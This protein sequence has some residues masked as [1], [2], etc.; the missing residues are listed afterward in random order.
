[1]ASDAPR[2][3]SL[4]TR[5]RAALG[6]LPGISEERMMGGICFLLDGNM[7]G[8]VNRNKTTGAGH[9]MFRIGKE[10]EAD[11]AARPEAEPVVMGGR[12]MGGMFYVAEEA[13]T[14]AVL[15]D[16]V[17]LSLRFVGALPAKG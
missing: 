14:D 6:G 15:K 9:F 11:G 5:M 1:M 16:W 12:R 13:C 10:H 3:E 8:G 17:A 4:A 7:L 2:E